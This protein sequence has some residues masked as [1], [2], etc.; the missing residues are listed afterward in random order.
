MV[1]MVLINHRAGQLGETGPL[2]PYCQQW[3][4]FHVSRMIENQD[5]A[6][7]APMRNFKGI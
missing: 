4:K 1:Y 3:Q 6:M 7:Y 5:R 2:R